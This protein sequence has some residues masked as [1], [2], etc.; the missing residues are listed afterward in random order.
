V[1]GATQAGTYGAFGLE[2]FALFCV[3]EII[4][5]GG[6]VIDYEY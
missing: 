5:R 4:G 2:L 6:S 1:A 3:G